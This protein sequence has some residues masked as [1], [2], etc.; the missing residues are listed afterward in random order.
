MSRK[1]VKDLTYDEL[2]ELVDNNSDIADKASD[3]FDDDVRFWAEEYLQGHPR[4]L[5]YSLFGWNGSDYI[6]FDD[7]GSEEISWL[8]KQNQSF[9]LFDDATMQKIDRIEELL[10]LMDD[11]YY[12]ED[13]TKYA[14]YESEYDDLKSEI[15]E[16]LY[17]VIGKDI[18]NK[19]DIDIQADTVSS[20]F[21]EFFKEGDYVDTDTWEIHNIED[22]E[23]EDAARLDYD[24]DEQLELPTL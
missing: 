5:D 7:I 12:D 4:S 10:G 11:A 19:W 17:S 6:E 14:E 20:Y 16:A 23:D 1:W 2:K 21:D 8:R 22:E 9:G 3:R 24:L 13:D 15:E 18:Y